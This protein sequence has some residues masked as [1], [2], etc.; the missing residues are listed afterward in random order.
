MRALQVE[1]LFDAPGD[2]RRVIATDCAERLG[3]ERDGAQVL[4]DRFDGGRS[5]AVF[6]RLAL[7]PGTPL[8]LQLGGR[9]QLAISPGGGWT[10]R[11]GAGQA[12]VYWLPRAPVSREVDAEQRILKEAPAALSGLTLDDGGLG[13]GFSAPL[14]TVDLVAWRFDDAASAD[15]LDGLSPLERQPWYLWGSHTPYRRPADVYEHHHFGR[16]Y[17]RGFAWPHQ[18]KICS[19]NDAHALAV[20]LDGLLRSTGRPLYARLREQILL[21]VLARQGEDG[22]F[23]H[24]EWSAGME[25]HYRLHASGMHLL[26]DTLAQGRDDAVV[27]LALARAV[28][29]TA[30]QTDTVDG[31]TW[32]LHDELEKDEA[33]MAAGPFRWIPSRAFGKKPSNMLVL[34]THLDTSVA[35]DRWAALTGEQRHAAAVASGRALLDRLLAQRPAEALYRTFF[36]FVRLTLL[37][38]GRASQLPLWQRAFKRLA[39]Q[40][41]I[42]RLPDL[43]RRWPRL[44]MPGG[45]ID[46]ELSLR[47]WAHHYLPINLMDLARLQRRLP[48]PAVEAA[49]HE[50]AR[51]TLETGIVERWAELGYEKYAL[52]FWAEALYHLCQ[53]FPARDD[54]RQALV[55]AVLKLEDTA[56]GLPP[57]LLGANAEALALQAQQP[58]PVPAD[59]R[60]RVVNLS[61]G[62]V[63]EILVVNP[64]KTALP[65]QWAAHA[66]RGAAPAELAPR[67]AWH[68]K[69]A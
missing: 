27:R 67:A 2:A 11:P 33:A 6:V 30:A 37:P 32:F 26:L 60:L 9:W 63:Q 55:Q 18:R 46:R 48:T 15:A 13:A 44:V 45:Y 17:E 68:G 66:P 49:L 4:L 28:D 12:P 42:P 64:T 62:A 56:Q 8:Q 19:E 52:G 21:S 7:E 54:Y 10:A 38:S 47:V 69:P 23:R 50:A 3:F 36:W 16:V 53:L 39:W 25:C 57:S 29:F 20:T 22:A 41:L 51:F 31:A 5:R 34:N 59:A 24:G 1:S 14:A 43:K 61:R 58:C 40:K 35:L 65:L